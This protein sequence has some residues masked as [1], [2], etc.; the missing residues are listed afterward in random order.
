MHIPR[1]SPHDIVADLDESLHCLQT[2]SIELYWLYRD[3][4]ERPVADILETLNSPVTQGKIRYFGCSNWRVERIEEAIHY[5]TEHGLTG[6]VGNQGMW[7]FAVPNPIEDSRIAPMDDQTLDFHR[8]T[9]L[10]IVAYTSQAHGFFSKASSD[11][12]ADDQIPL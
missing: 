7:S 3:D 11:P 8:E 5:A 1:L 6:F 4:P 9:G 12:A 10:A 2:E